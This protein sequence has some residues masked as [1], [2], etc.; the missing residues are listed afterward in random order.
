MAKTRGVI[1]A[2]VALAVLGA[3]TVMAATAVGLRAVEFTL[4][5]PDRLLAAC[6]QLVPTIGPG[7]IAAVALIALGAVVG[8]RAVRSV[9][10]QLRAHRRFL[11]GLRVG[12]YAGAH[13]RGVV[14]VRDRRAL[15]FCAGFI[16]PRVYVSTGALDALDEVQL[17]AV[18]THERHHARCRDPLRL[19]AARVAFDGLFFVPVL[20]HL[21]ERYHAFAE[22]AADRASVGRH[23]RAPLA[24]ALL[25][26]GEGA[27]P[28]MVA[29]I[30]PERV[31]HLLGRAAR[32]ELPTALVAASVLVL[33][34]IAGVV[35]AVDR[36]LEGSAVNLSLVL[37]QSCMVVM[38]ALSAA[39]LASAALA[40]RRRRS[41]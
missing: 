27:T 8:A 20:R 15:A 11:R 14:V 26:L 17:E 7:E 24:S 16:R 38:A 35:L 23:G 28:G 13:S 30:A 33:V 21:A 19:L 4:A 10:R 6:R 12:D 9:L 37:S 5:A 3:S 25:V 39:L 34:G 32:W 40:Y 1:G 29:G 31:D 36:A 22:L 41:R 2:G 18:L